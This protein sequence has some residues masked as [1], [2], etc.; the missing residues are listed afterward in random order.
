MKL[1]ARK[2]WPYIGVLGVAILIA[3]SPTTEQGG[4]AAVVNSGAQFSKADAPEST[5]RERQSQLGHVELE[6]LNEQQAKA[7]SGKKVS[8]AFSPTSWYVAPPRRPEPPPPPPPAPTAPPLP[9]TYLGRYEDPPKRLVILSIGNRVYTVSQGEVIDGN[10][11]VAHITDDAVELVYLPL[12]I[13][14]SISTVG[15]PDS[16]QPRLGVGENYRRP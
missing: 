15:V 8:N 14:Q 10:Y 5:S 11:R 12:N 3:L 2:T 6:K 13:S 16:T 4:S 7:A 1:P 9:F